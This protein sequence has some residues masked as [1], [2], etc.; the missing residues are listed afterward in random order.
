MKAYE[1][2]AESSYLDIAETVWNYVNDYMITTE[3]A[4]EGKNSAGAKSLGSDC[5]RKQLR[6]TILGVTN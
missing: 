3:Q 1:V 2:Y 4:N 6:I 5:S